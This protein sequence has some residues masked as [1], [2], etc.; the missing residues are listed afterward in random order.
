MIGSPLR[1]IRR[2]SA[3]ANP[4]SGIDEVSRPVT[5]S[6]QVAALTKSERSAP[7]CAFQLPRETLSRISA[8]RVPV[9]GM[10]NSASARHIRA[11]PSSLDSEYS[12]I[13]LS[14]PPLPRCARVRST[15]RRA[16]L[17]TRA[18]TSSGRSAVAISGG[19]HSGSGR[20]WAAR[21]AARKGVAG[22]SAPANP[23]NGPSPSSW[24]A[25]PSPIANAMC[26]PA[27]KTL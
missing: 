9:S 4:S 11:T 6:P 8:S 22:C 16:T 18:D 1:A 13:R 2:L 12:W 23:E 7:R 5:I 27:L 3:A 10:R 19:R 14:T 24:T 17:A 25:R 26:S 21:I 15:S 20:R